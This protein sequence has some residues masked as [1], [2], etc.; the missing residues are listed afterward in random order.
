MF[1]Q[2]WCT[3]SAQGYKQ[4]KTTTL[5]HFTFKDVTTA[6]GIYLFFG[7]LVLVKVHHLHIHNIR[8]EQSCGFYIQKYSTK[9][10]AMVFFF[11]PTEKC[12]LRQT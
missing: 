12:I 11:F 7:Q 6:S 8:Q 1:S 10:L 9:Q 5:R 3:A 4:K 2:P